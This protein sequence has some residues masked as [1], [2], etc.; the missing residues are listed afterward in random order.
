MKRGGGGAGRGGEWAGGEWRDKKRKL[1]G[2]LEEYLDEV[3]HEGVETKKVFI[4][5]FISHFP[6]FD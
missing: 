4:Y 3:A 2:Y 6:N 5:F 1:K